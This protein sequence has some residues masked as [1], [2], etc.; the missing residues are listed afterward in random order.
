M[1]KYVVQMSAVCCGQEERPID[2]NLSKKATRHSLHFKI[3]ISCLRE[4]TQLWNFWGHWQIIFLKLHCFEG[5]FSFQNPHFVTELCPT[6]PCGPR[7]FCT[8]S[9]ASSQGNFL[10]P[11]LESRLGWFDVLTASCL[12]DKEGL[13]SRGPV[14]VPAA[15]R[16]VPKVGRHWRWTQKMNHWLS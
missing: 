5:F 2:A 6:G 13:S 8:T 1:R 10:F 7:F 11:F 3:S 12:E 16:S 15:A 14:S 9:M 4:E